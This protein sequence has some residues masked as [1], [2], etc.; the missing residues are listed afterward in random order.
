MD[1]GGAARVERIALAL[2]EISPSREPA[3]FKGGMFPTPK[4]SLF[5]CHG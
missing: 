1:R 4:K 3:V 5:A 2:E